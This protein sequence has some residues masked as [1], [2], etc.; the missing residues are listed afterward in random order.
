MITELGPSVSKSSTGSQNFYA[1]T[2]SEHKFNKTEIENW[3]PIRF[4][5]GSS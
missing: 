4:N 2:D 3:L 5:P 1:P